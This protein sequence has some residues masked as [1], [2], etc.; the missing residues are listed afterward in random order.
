[1]NYSTLPKREVMDFFALHK[2]S[3][4]TSEEVSEALPDIGKSSVYRIV[5]KLV[6]DG[7]LRKVGSRGRSALYQFQDKVH[8]PHHMHVK[9]S[10]C[11]RTQHLDEETSRKIEK[12]V[13]STMGFKAFNSTVL[14]GICEE[15][16]AKEER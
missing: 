13:E 1:M 2:N 11:G 4:F 6:E 8:C 9:C 14:D 5:P 10:V 7:C 3:S 15:C 12:M 16:R